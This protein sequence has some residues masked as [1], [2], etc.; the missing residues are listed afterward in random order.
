LRPAPNDSDPVQVAGQMAGI[1]AAALQHKLCQPRGKLLYENSDAIL[2]ESPLANFAVDAANGPFVEYC[3]VNPAQGERTFEVRLKFVTYLK[4]CSGTNPIIGH[5]WKRWI[6]I[7]QDYFT[8][9]VTEG[10]ATFRS[11]LLV[12][13]GRWPDQYRNQLFH[14]IPNGFKRERI[15]V[16]PNEAG[17]AVAYRYVDRE[18]PLTYNRRASRVEAYMTGSWQQSGERTALALNRAGLFG[19]ATSLIRGPQSGFVGNLFA[20]GTSVAAMQLPKYSWHFLVR[21]WGEPTSTRGNLTALALAIIAARFPIDGLY[22]NELIVTHDLVGK[23]VEVQKTVSYGIERILPGGNFFFNWAARFGI[24]AVLLDSSF[25]SGENHLATVFIN[26]P[27]GTAEMIRVNDYT[28][29]GHAPPYSNASRAY[30]L[31]TLVA[32][33][34]SGACDTPPTPPAITLATP[35]TMNAP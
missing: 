8:E 26:G 11:D 21:I 28:R 23:F 27:E 12:S 33:V 5:R 9:I 2:L 25:D 30:W 17:T 20:T 10:E 19:V 16:I 24:P 22:Q 18:L 7:D 34:L 6:D 1:T 29:A 3:R 35:A 14:P 15:T 13:M 31:G 32:Q 4:L